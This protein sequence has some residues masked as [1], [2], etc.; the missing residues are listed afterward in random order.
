LSISVFDFFV[1]ILGSNESADFSDK[2]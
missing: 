1:V 2:D